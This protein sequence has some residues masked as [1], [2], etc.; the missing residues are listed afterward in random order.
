MVGSLHRFLKELDPEGQ[1]LRHPARV[2]SVSGVR[3]GAANAEGVTAMYA[4]AAGDYGEIWAPLLRPYG[5]QLL[6]RLPLEEARR[7]LDLGCGVGR[8]LPD[9][10]ERARSAY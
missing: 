3:Q 7:V 8:L 2:G 1:R 6:D 5:L 9:I 4:P 10:A